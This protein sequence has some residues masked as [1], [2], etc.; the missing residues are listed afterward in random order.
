MLAWSRKETYHLKG[1]LE[2][3]RIGGLDLFGL[4]GVS[5]GGAVCLWPGVWWV[6]AGTFSGPP[7]F[8]GPRVPHGGGVS[9]VV[10]GFPDAGRGSRFLGVVSAV[11]TAAVVFARIFPSCLAGRVGVAPGMVNCCPRQTAPRQDRRRAA[12]GSAGQR[13]ADGP[14]GQQGSRAEPGQPGGP[15]SAAGA[16]G[17]LAIPSSSD[18]NPPV[19][20]RPPHPPA[21]VTDLDNPGRAAHTNSP[22]PRAGRTT[23]NNC[24]AQRTEPHQHRRPGKASMCAPG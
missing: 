21:P 3:R 1:R 7:V 24:R 17:L 6:S 23:M 13:R 15:G 5:C 4:G 10:D 22:N 12:P 9:R 2:N 14:G 11:W 16:A 19:A 18:R 8:S 20:Q